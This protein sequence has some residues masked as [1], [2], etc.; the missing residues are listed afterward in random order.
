MG[1]AGGTLM[2]DDKPTPGMAAG[3]S[4]SCSSKL[5][6][7]K[8]IRSVRFASKCCRRQLQN[9]FNAHLLQDFWLSEPP[10]NVCQRKKLHETGE[11]W[12]DFLLGVPRNAA[13]K[14]R[15]GGFAALLWVL[16]YS[17][18]TSKSCCALRRSTHRKLVN[19]SKV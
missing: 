15:E 1:G 17:H 5:K 16:T 9:V 13:K 8:K 10:L 18:Q 19:S 3:I 2:S 14:T 7:L 11:S 12:I 4:V 6:N